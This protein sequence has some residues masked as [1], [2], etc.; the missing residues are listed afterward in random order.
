MGAVEGGSNYWTD[1]ISRAPYRAV[2]PAEPVTRLTP[3]LPFAV[4]EDVEGGEP[5][6]HEVGWPEVRTGIAVMARDFPEHFGH[7]LSGDDD[8]ETADVF[9]Q[10][11]VFG[12]LVY[13]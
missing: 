12:K 3:R 11:A 4:Y 8:A 7:F 13:G 9:L 2:D 10:C 6:P 1:G 5:V